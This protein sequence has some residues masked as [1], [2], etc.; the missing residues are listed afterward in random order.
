[1]MIEYPKLRKIESRSDQL[2]ESCDLW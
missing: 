1:M 2:V